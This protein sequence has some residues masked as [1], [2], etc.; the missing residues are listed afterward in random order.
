MAIQ[1]PGKMDFWLRGAEYSPKK[2]V[3]FF[4][5][6]A[7]P[8]NL[9]KYKNYKDCSSSTSIYL[10]ANAEGEPN[11]PHS[12]KDPG[13]YEL[14]LNYRDSPL[15]KKRRS[16]MGI[17]N[18][19]AEIAEK[20]AEKNLEAC[21][22]EQL[23]VAAALWGLQ[24]RNKTI[25]NFVIKKLKVTRETTEAQSQLVNSFYYRCELEGEGFKEKQ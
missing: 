19:I 16:D 6:T 8:E 23:V 20:L 13:R 11:M 24:H 18:Q 17:R 1:I 4:N 5:Q 21:I 25:N 15:N 14:F 22:A 3:R 12:F 10:L 9:R 2:K 7:R